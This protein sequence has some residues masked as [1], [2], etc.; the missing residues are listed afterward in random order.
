MIPVLLISKSFVRQNRW[1]LMALAAW[2]FLFG[3]FLWSPQG[4]SSYADVA[5]VLQQEIIYGVAVVTF[6]ASSAIYNERR[7]RRIIAVLSKGISRMQYLLGLLLGS[8]C[9][10]AAYFAAIG[11]SL[12]WLLGYSDDVFAAVSTLFLRGCLACLWMA[13]LALLF[14]TFVYPFFAA[15]FSAAIAAIPIAMPRANLVFAPAALMRNAMSFSTAVNWTMVSIAL[16]ESAAILALGAKIFARR[17][18]TVS[19]E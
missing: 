19:V 2:P 17:D 15:A 14:S 4:K 8:L 18:V 7:S 9:C 3:A 1:L 10:A 16:L 12:L 13:A 5:E 6:L 11:G